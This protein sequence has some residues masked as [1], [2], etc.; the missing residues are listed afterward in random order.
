M[1]NLWWLAQR[2]RCPTGCS[3]LVSKI[4]KQYFGIELEHLRT[5]LKQITT[6]YVGLM[7]LARKVAEKPL[8]CRPKVL[9]DGQLAANMSG[10][11]E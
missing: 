7:V 10:Q 9:V 6:T 3:S 11:E 2:F 5:P 1:I 4:T 8:A